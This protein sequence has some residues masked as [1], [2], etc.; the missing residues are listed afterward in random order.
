MVDIFVANGDYE[1]IRKLAD[2]TG[3]PFWVYTG[4]SSR[5]AAGIRHTQAWQPWKY[6]AESSWFWAYNYHNGDPYND[7]DGYPESTASV[8]WPPRQ[9][10]GPLVGSVSWEGLREAVD[11][12]RYLRTL[13]WMLARAKSPAAGGI[14]SSFDAMRVDVPQGR[15]LRLLEGNEHDTVNAV[16]KSKYVEQYRRR[17][18][19]WINELLLAE[20]AA[21]H[22]LRPGG[23]KAASARGR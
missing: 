5:D 11:D 3:K 9:P 2:E 10:G 20:P 16:D 4:V 17:V 7:L 6:K 14:R 1:A 13:E 15:A 8:V 18:A 23:G 12:M 22:E 19:G 21:F